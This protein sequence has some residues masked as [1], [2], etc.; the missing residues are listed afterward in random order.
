MYRAAAVL[1]HPGA[2]YNLSIYYGQ[3]RGGLV[4][5]IDT[6]TRW[7]RLAAVKGQEQ[8]ID[9][10]KS[11]E[12]PPIQETKPEQE[13]WVPF[14]SY[15]QSENIVPTQSSLFVESVNPFSNINK[16]EATVY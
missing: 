13:K 6:A 9:A 14:A 1:E 7:L 2:M 15:A 12:I 5:N 8:A 4:R 3:G 16:C 11:L 10:L